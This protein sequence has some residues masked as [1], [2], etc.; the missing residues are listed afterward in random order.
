VLVVVVVLGI[1]AASVVGATDV[2]DE[3]AGLV[4]GS[5]NCAG[6]P[7]EVVGEDVEEDFE[8]VEVG[9]EEVVVGGS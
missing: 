2:V 5:K 7:D 6:T 4:S 8:V 3:V 1:G 9:L